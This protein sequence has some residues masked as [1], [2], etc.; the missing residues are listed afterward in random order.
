MFLRIYLLRLHQWFGKVVTNNVFGIFIWQPKIYQVLALSLRSGL[1]LLPIISHVMFGLYRGP[2]MVRLFYRKHVTSRFILKFLLNF[3]HDKSLLLFSF[4]N[5]LFIMS[6]EGS[7]G[8]LVCT[9]R[10]L[11]ICNACMFFN[12]IHHTCLF[13]HSLFQSALSRS[14]QR[15]F[16]EA[17]LAELLLAHWLLL[18]DQ[19]C[20]QSRKNLRLFAAANVGQVI[21]RTVLG[22]KLVQVLYFIHHHLQVL[23]L[24][25]A[26]FTIIVSLLGRL[27]KRV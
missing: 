7:H 1:T 17:Q 9:I 23:W 5:V 26:D 25:G 18:F 16:A 19:R 12:C 11:N 15:A 6:L 10:Y 3:W 24:G 2:L 4:M 27:C 20:R 22:P 21:K 8:F 14:N 13:A